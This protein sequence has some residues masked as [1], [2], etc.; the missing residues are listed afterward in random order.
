M[1][2]IIKQSLSLR[3][4]GDGCT[5][6]HHLRASLHLYLPLFSWLSQLVP[7]GVPWPWCVREGISEPGR[8]SG[9]RKSHGH[10]GLFTLGLGC[11]PLKPT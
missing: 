3:T 8:G 1:K 9:M 5:S 7:A 2:L 10:H 4:G 11:G 6:G